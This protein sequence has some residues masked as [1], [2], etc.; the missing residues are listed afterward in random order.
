MNVLI[1]G[2]ESRLGQVIAKELAQGNRLRL[3]GDGE[4]PA[5]LVEGDEW[6]TGD[7]RDPDVAWR[8]VRDMQA[9]IHTGEPP[10]KLPDDDLACEQTLLDLRTRGTHVLFKAGVEAGVKR[11]V[12]GS[13]LEVFEAYPDDVYI[14]E[15]WRPMPSIDKFQLTRYLGEMT[16]REFARD[17]P[18]A[19]TVLRLGKL[20]V[21][22]EV[23][24]QEPDLMWVDYRDAAQAFRLALSRDAQSQL[25]WNRRFAVHHICA[26][27]PNPKYLVGKMQYGFQLQGF[28]PQ[29]NFESV[30]RGGDARKKCFF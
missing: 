30:W 23:D 20:V 4:A 14:S 16:A 3:W 27:I 26:N 17:F 25:M 28:E 9:I 13:T 12:Y 10:G 18:V 11:F 1:T 22:E 21:E 7:V 29:H 2:A 6:F 5:G 19:V 24:G 15:M 8:A